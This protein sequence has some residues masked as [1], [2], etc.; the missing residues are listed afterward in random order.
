MLVCERSGKTMNER[1]KEWMYEPKNTR[2]DT[3]T[4]TQTDTQTSTQ[5]D[6]QTSIWK[7]EN[8]NELPEY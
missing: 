1:N 8:M 5:T 7:N 2:T 4:G 3:Q 6:T